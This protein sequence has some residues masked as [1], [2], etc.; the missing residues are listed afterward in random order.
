MLQHSET[1]FNTLHHTAPHCN[2]LHVQ[3]LDQTV[4][5]ASVSAA[6]GDGTYDLATGTS[7]EG[8]IIKYAVPGK[9]IFKFP[10]DGT[11]SYRKHCNALQHT[12]THCNTCSLRW[13]AG[14]RG[15]LHVGLSVWGRGGGLGSRPK[16]CTVRDWG[17]GSSTI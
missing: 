7:E 6:H 5:F 9:F 16:K 13:N 12:A 1:H 11:Q 17:M 10:Y 3:R 4:R 14:L 15:V 8:P 2:I